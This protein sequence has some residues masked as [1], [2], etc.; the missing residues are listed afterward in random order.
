MLSLEKRLRFVE[1]LHG[2]VEELETGCV[3]ELIGGGIVLGTPRD[4]SI[5]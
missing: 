1:D 4:L 5:S 3:N 2:T